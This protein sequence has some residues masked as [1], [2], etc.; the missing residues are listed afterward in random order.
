MSSRLVDPQTGQSLVMRLHLPTRERQEAETDTAS[1]APSPAET[2]PAD[3]A[4]AEATQETEVIDK[5]STGS[6]LIG[7]F[8]RFRKANMTNWAAALTYFG[9]LSLFPAIIA[10]VSLL[11]V[12]GQSATQPILDN[13]A[14]V[15]PGPAR[16]VLTN[17]ITGVQSNGGA[18]TVVFIISIAVAFWSA[19]GYVSAFMDASNAVYGADESRSVFKR[20][21]LRLIVTAT[22][23][24]AIVLC[25]AA[26]VLTGG[27]ADRAGDILGV[28][29]TVVQVWDFA[30]IPVILLLVSFVFSVLYWAAPN[31]THKRFKWITAGSIAAL[32]IWLVA[33]AAFGEYVVNFGSYN[34]TYGTLG[35]AIMFLVWLWITNIAILFGATLNAELEFRSG[36]VEVA[37]AETTLRERLESQ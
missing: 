13:I 36:A 9:V 11:G 16:D 1:R 30:K 21:P 29:N 28:G 25:A 34:Q 32:V 4:P 17:A 10:V 5:P 8:N 35:G 14:T 3:P 23:F 33:S 19:S 37:T 7:G 6:P 22:I 12:I 18:S 24:T 31:V 27:F 2:Q 20:V 15:A 26:V